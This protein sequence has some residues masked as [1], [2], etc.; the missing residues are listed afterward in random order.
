MKESFIKEIKISGMHCQGCVSRVTSKL[1]EIKGVKEVNVSLEKQN[2][3]IESKKEIDD[4]TI[5]SMIEMLGFGVVDIIK[6]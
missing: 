6:K 5:S 1:K 4:E 3:I 2:A